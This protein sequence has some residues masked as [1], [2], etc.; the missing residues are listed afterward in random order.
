MKAVVVHGAGDLRVDERPDPVARRGRG[1][2]RDGVGRGLRLRPGL[3]AARRRPA[4]PCCAA[5]WCSATRWPA[6]SPRSAPASTGLR[7]RAAGHR[8]PGRAGRRRLPARPD[9]RPHQPLPADPLLRVGG[10][11]PAHRRRVQRAAG[12]PR[13]PDPAA[14]RRRRAPSTERWP[15]RS[16][17]R[18]TRCTGPA[19]CAAATSWS[20]GPGRSARLVVA[21]AKYRGAASVV[22]AD[23][24]DASLAV[25]KA[26]GAD[27]VRNLA[28]GDTLPDDAELVFEASGAPAA[29]GG[30]APGDRPRRHA[31]PGRQPARHGRCPPCSAT[32]SPARSPGSGAYRFVEEISD[33]LAAHARRPRRVPADHPPVRR[34]TQAEEALAVAGD[35][36]SG[37]Q[38]GD[39]A[40]RRG[41]AVRRV[42]V[43]TVGETMALLDAPASGRLGAARCRSASAGRSR[44]SRSG[45]PGSGWTCT[46]G[47]PGRR[48]RAGHVRHA[49]DPGRGRP[50]GR[51]PRPRRPDRAD[52]QGA[53]Q[54]QAVAGALLP[55]RQRGV[56]VV[57]GRRRRRR[58]RDRRGRTCCTSPASP[59]PS[60][61]LRW[62]RSSGPSRW[63]GPPAPSC[64]STS[65]TARPCG[66]TTR[67]HRC[68]PGSPRPPT[69]SSPDRRRLRWCSAGTP[70]P[71]SFDEGEMLARELAKRGP[72]TVVVKLG[73]L[74]ALA[75]SGD[76]VHR[77]PALPVDGRRPGR[78]RRRLRRRLPERGRRGRIGARRPAHGQRL[79]CGRLPGTRRLGR[80][81]HPDDAIST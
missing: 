44:T 37:Q 9:R 70:G 21:A 13:R 57:G 79:R 76:E 15:S 63:P 66:A 5:R 10:V 34:S 75:L 61:P 17:S 60:A 80:P 35:R 45:W 42:P 41:C 46:L 39:A 26:M 40:A 51:R 55:Q 22:A 27:E 73:A 7:G 33:A 81:A 28:A 58:R 72:A 65:T 38:Q 68:W 4:P 52:A 19:T 47:Q 20:T 78:R 29:L 49:G 11:R 74:G 24:A 32:W 54:R 14:A 77:A 71:S 12:G 64:P 31:R 16:P 69:W 6:G 23:I 18:C 2:D 1:A 62:P 67:R 50:G 8:P 3:L 36:S 56:A 59:P 53:P 48:R 25:A 43:V 30:R